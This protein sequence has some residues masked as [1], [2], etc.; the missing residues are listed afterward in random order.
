V[1]KTVNVG[2]P[3]EN[4]QRVNSLFED[5]MSLKKHIKQLEQQL[6]NQPTVV[7]KVVEVDKYITVEVER[8]A[9]GDLKEAARLLSI[10]EFNQQKATANDIYNILL[11]SSED[12]VK[13]R[14]GFWAVPLP[15]SSD[16][17]NDPNSDATSQ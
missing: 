16:D 11:K 5:N 2:V 3:M 12:E 10:S 13:R 6:I 9:T 14:L 17:T 1:E 7:E 8:A 15:K 4:N